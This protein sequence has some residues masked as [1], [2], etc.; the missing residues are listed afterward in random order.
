MA[1]IAAVLS[2]LTFGVS[3][4]LGG[5]SAKRLSAA[6]TGV[7][8]ELSGLVV[9]FIASVIV[10]GSPSTAD[11]IWGIV[12]GVSGGV[13]LVAFYWAMSKGKMSVV[14]P[15]AALMSAIL[16]LL[17]GLLTGER[18]SAVAFSGTLLALL[19]IVLVSREPG[20]P[21]DP[22]ESK[23]PTDRR[24]QRRILIAAIGSGLAIGG[25]IVAVAQTSKASGF[26]PLVAGRFTA[27]L[28]I[29]AVMIQLRPS[30]SDRRGSVLALGAGALDV[31]AN[32]LFVIAA[33]N[34]LLTLVGVIGAM[35]PASTVVLARVLLHERL[36]RHQ[37]IGL[38]LAALA[39]TA[40][41]VG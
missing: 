35:Y 29:G 27:T 33:R 5:L 28:V 30:S 34:G 7:I 38:A 10:G 12:A 16:P 15:V 17:V 41:A 26:W 8:A 11:W 13:G 19:A 36:A 37:L 4:F 40:I 1:L 2:A 24:V 22:L 9:V 31:C 32:M 25:Y 18:P 3:D 23:P 21:V 20:D 6:T 14:A 39:V